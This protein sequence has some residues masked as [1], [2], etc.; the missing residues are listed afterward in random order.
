M[1]TFRVVFLVLVFLEF[2]APTQIA[3]GLCSPLRLL[4]RAREAGKLLI[5]GSRSSIWFA[6]LFCDGF[7]E[8]LSRCDNAGVLSLDMPSGVCDVDVSGDEIPATMESVPQVDCRPDYALWAYNDMFTQGGS[9]L[10]WREQSCGP[11]WK[12]ILHGAW[13]GINCGNSKDQFLEYL[14]ADAD[15]LEV[16]SDESEIVLA[17]LLCTVGD[18]VLKLR[19]LASARTVLGWSV[20]HWGSHNHRFVATCRNFAALSLAFGRAKSCPKHLTTSGVGRSS[21]RI[22]LRTCAVA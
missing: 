22:S 8:S 13:D 16:H 5:R 11:L 2:L 18:D 20:G 14:V 9:R 12:V 19:F 7:A 6:W 10:Q 17:R 15:A 1:V 21:W 4:R 3:P